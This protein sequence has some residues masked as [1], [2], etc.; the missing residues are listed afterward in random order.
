MSLRDCPFCP[1]A[2]EANEDKLIA[3]NRSA[4]A[5]FDKYPVSQ[6]HVLV[7][8]NRHEANFFKL[9]PEEQLDVWKLLNEVNLV[10][11]DMFQPDQ[12][13]SRECSFKASILAVSLEN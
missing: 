1:M 9:L 5:F 10:L 13:V 3:V 2:E 8:P 11:S 6:G 4:V 7:I 12:F